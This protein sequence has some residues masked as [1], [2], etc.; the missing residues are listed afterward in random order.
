MKK[1][2]WLTSWY[3]NM[4]DPFSGD[5]IK[6]QAEAVSLFQ[7]VQILFVGK[8][9]PSPL[10]ENVKQVNSFTNLKEYLL[11]YPASGHD[12]LF[13]KGRSFTSYFL[14]HLQIIRQLHKKN[15]L[16]DL[17][18]V[19]VAWKSGL[20]A[21]Y[22]KW[23][24]KIPYVLT[25]H[26]SG[27]YPQAKD[28]LFRKS[29]LERYWTR[30]IIGKA[31][32]LITVSEALGMQI[33]QSWMKVPFQQIPNVVNTRFFF[34]EKNKRAERFRFIHIST[35]KYP[36]NPEGILRAFAALRKTMIDA[37]LVLVGPVN[38]GLDKMIRETGLPESAIRC[39]GEIPYKNVGIEL[40]HSSVLI[41]FSHYENMPCVLLESLCSGI[42]VI[43]SRVGGI[44]EVVDETNG[45]LVKPGDE[46]DLLEAM[47]TMISKESSYDREKI[48]SRA[49]AQFSYE[50]VGKEILSVYESVLGNH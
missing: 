35:L 16:P 30:R 1:V 48:S 32:Q 33:R 24:Y 8:Y 50:V 36:K 5:F 3:P 38:T 20:I 34:P 31:N 21:L 14:K 10:K 9:S 15:E 49:T 29:Y 47:K 7:P 4:D 18:H 42:P 43:A 17:V 23:K 45:I 13:T 2:L 39:T 40:Q 28:S 26:W 41:L 46:N 12:N 27:Y 6:R 25:E 44:P 37:E 19:Q 22:L 11:Y